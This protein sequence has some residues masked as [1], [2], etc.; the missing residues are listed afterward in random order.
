MKI[1][2]V[3]LFTCIVLFAGYAW[4][5]WDTYRHIRRILKEKLK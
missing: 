4:G 2:A 1:F 5:A 3:T